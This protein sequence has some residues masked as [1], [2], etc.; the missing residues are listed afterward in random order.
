MSASGGSDSGAYGERVRDLFDRA[1]KAEN[2]GEIIFTGVGGVA[3]AIGGALSSGI[4]TV[5]DVFI[6]PAQA[7]IEGVIGLVGSIFGGASTIIDLGA[8]GS[9]ISL[10][11]SGLFQS[12]LSFPIAVGVILLGLYLVVAYTSEEPTTN[13]LPLVGS[14]LDLP[15]PFFT[16]SEED[17]K[18]N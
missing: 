6:L 4:L 18:N 15:T 17:D 1:S 7:F 2:I 12:P 10:G 16:D 14:G 5:A 9:A 8:L 13:F 3:L 11:P